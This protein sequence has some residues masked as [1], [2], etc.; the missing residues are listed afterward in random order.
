M[1]YLCYSWHFKLRDSFWKA[2]SQNKS[3]TIKM[4]I[5]IDELTPLPV[6]YTKEIILNTK[7][8]K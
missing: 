1:F 7:Q 6:I 2:M 5:P 4:F 3:R 8:E